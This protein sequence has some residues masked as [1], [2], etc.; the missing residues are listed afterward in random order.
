MA[1]ENIVVTVI[2]SITA[3]LIAWFSFVTPKKLVARHKDIERAAAAATSADNRTEKMEQRS[4]LITMERVKLESAERKLIV[5]MGDVMA[6]I[7]RSI[8]TGDKNGF[9]TRA[10]DRYTNA[11]D[12]LQAAESE[13]IIK[14]SSVK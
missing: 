14:T 3:I 2:T 5:A 11:S 4:K 6:S 9:L 7:V 13:Y 8:Q 12:A 10:M 1:F